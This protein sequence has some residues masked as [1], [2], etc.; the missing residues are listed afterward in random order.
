M[1]LFSPNL[2]SQEQTRELARLEL[3]H[4][5]KAGKTLIFVSGPAGC[6][7]SHLAYEYLQT[8]LPGTLL[9]AYVDL[10]GDCFELSLIRD[11]FSKL[12]GILFLDE[13]SSIFREDSS[14]ERQAVKDI[15]EYSFAGNVQVV[16]LFQG[17]VSQAMA[18]TPYQMLDFW[19]W[20]GHLAESEKWAPI[21]FSQKHADHTLV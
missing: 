2:L 1:R 12:E 17:E 8:R 20:A 11:N 14:L 15:I 6:G 4:H 13:F 9:P 7:K 5:L 16:C 19:N 18:N 21:T 3:S 10:S